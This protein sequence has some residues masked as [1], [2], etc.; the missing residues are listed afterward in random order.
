MPCPMPSITLPPHSY[1]AQV[2]L[3]VQPDLHGLI[4]VIDGQFTSLQKDAVW[5][6]PRLRQAAAIC[7]SLTFVRKNKVVGDTAE[8]KLCKAVEANFVVSSLL[9]YS[10]FKPSKA[11]HTCTC[12]AVPY[13]TIDHIPACRYCVMLETSNKMVSSLPRHLIHIRHIIA[14]RTLPG[15]PVS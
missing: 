6:P 3:D 9:K 14:Q 5:W 8:L 4:P 13:G 15:G 12:H 1:T 7:N 10:L 11:S 2:Y